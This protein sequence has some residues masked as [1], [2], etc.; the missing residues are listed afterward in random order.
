MSSAAAL[1][2][3]AVPAVALADNP[4]AELS[5]FAADGGKVSIKHH[6]PHK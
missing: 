4:D 2:V 1:P 3:L 6:Q 5:N